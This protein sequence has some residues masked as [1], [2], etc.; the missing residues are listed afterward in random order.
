ME[1]DGKAFLLGI[2][3]LDAASREL[4]DCDNVLMGSRCR[5]MGG[6]SDEATLRLI[7]NDVHAD[8]FG[9]AGRG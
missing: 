4:M 8:P 1:L 2:Q 7:S 9:I 6:P 5:P 3:H